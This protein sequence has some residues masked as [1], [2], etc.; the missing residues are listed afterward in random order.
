V[1]GFSE[2]RQASGRMT[3]R[4]KRPSRAAVPS[5]IDHRTAR[6]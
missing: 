4:G 6:L 3:G 1:A 5:G 2:M